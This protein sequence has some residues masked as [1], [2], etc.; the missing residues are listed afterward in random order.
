MNY[1][2]GGHKAILN[3]Q[4]FSELKAP[5]KDRGNKDAA[6]AM[7]DRIKKAN[8]LKNSRLGTKAENYFPKNTAKYHAILNS[9]EANI[10]KYDKYKKELIDKVM[11]TIMRKTMELYPP[12][13]EDLL[14]LRTSEND[15]EVEDKS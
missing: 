14:K 2:S 3:F 7:L 12:K 5:S 15:N 1:D 10:A 6:T 13:P 9:S 11:E 4:G 8:K